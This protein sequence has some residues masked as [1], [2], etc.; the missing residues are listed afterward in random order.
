VESS[1]GGLC[2]VHGRGTRMIEFLMQGVAL[3][4]LYALIAIPP[5]LVWMTAHSLD[6]AVGGYAVFGG[7]AYAAAGGGGIGLLV[8]LVAGAACGAFSASLFLGLRRLGVADPMAPG[9]VS[10]GVLFALGSLALTFFGVDPSY[11]PNFDG[12]VMIGGVRVNPQ[13]FVNLAVIATVTA[14]ALLILRYTGLGRSM[15]A[16]AVSAVDAALVGIRVARL[17]CGVFVL[18]G[19]LGVSATH[20]APPGNASALG[21]ALLDRYR[22]SNIGK[23]VLRVWPDAP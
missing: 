5:S 8:A 4:A 19:V 13:T 10:V 1:E 22:G 2:L 15:R 6:L 17:Q 11:R 23:L 7:L 3:G 12:P 9:L 16:S 14:C 20:A 18:A 21:Q